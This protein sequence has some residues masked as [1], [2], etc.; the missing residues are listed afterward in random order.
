MKTKQTHMYTVLVVGLVCWALLVAPALAVEVKLSGQINRAMIW[1]DNGNDSE[2]FHV[3]NDNSSTRF[4]LTGEQDLGSIKAGVVWENEFQSNASNN[5]DIGQNSDGTSSFNDRKL[6]AWFGGFFGRFWIGQGDG[7]AN[8]TSEVDLSGTSVIMYSGVNDTAGSFT[9]RDDDDNTVATI[10]STRSNFD[11]LSRNDRLRYD[12][13]T[14]AG[15]SFA[16]SITNGNAWEAAGRWSQEFNRLGK[17]AAAIGYIDNADRGNPDDSYSQLG[18]SVSWLHTT[19]LNATLSYGLRSIENQSDDPTNY[20][21]KVGYTWGIHAAALEY[22]LTSDL[23]ASG[24]DSSNVGAAYVIKPW[25]GVEFYGTIRSYSLDRSG[26]D[27]NNINQF[28]FGT[29]V[30]F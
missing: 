20:Y 11:G 5:V 26:V 30:K 14:F 24:D 3:D 22:G 7:A 17:F 13:P 15:F 16:A 8:G 10:G 6:E 28:M 18:T 12:T 27:T 1:A 29:R 9:F 25:S 21:L 2:L 19:G 4:R 23:A